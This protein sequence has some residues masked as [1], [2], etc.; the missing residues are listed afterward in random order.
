MFDAFGTEPPE[1]DDE[2][3]SLGFAFMAALLSESEMVEI[4]PGV[5]CHSGDG[6]IWITDARK[7]P[8]E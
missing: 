8:G 6:V 2:D 3:L 7:D 4:G 5:W 1:D